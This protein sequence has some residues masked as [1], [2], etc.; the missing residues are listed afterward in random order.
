[1]FARIH[2]AFIAFGGS[3]LLLAGLIALLRWDPFAAD[4]TGGE[5]LV[6]YCA[7]A[8]R[9]PLEATARDYE[10]QFGQ[11]VYLRVGPSQ[12]ILTNLL[13]GKGGDLFLPADDSFIDL[14]RK[15]DAIAEVLPLAR[16]TAVAI[17]R[18]GYTGTIHSW[19]DFVDRGHT[20]GIAHTGSTAIGKLLRHRLTE[21]G[22]WESVEKCEPTYLTSVNEVANTVQVGGV[23][24]GVVWDAVA[25]Q[26]AK[27]K[28]RIV[29]L[30]ELDSVTA[31]VQIALTT[32]STQPDAALRFV[33]FLRSK[34]GGARYFKEQGY[35]DF[36]TEDTAQQP[37][38]VVYAGAMLR[39]AVEQ[40]LKEFATREHVKI[41]PVY[42]GC[43]IL[44]SQMRAGQKPDLYFACDTR[45]MDQVQDLF[46]PAVEV[47][48]NQLVIA[49][50]KGNP[51]GIQSLRDLGKPGLRVGVGH[52]QQCALGAI[53][54]Q[55][56]LQAG[57]Y[58]AVRKNIVVVSPTGDYLINQLRSGIGR[59]NPELDAVV[60]YK[61]NVMLFP[62]KLDGIPVTGIPCAA[63][64]QPLAVSRTTASRE[65]CEKLKTAIQSARSKE[66]FEKLGF[67]WQPTPKA[68]E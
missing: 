61:S 45:F 48:S 34:D 14:A 25:L 52:E 18:P 7:E 46:D 33:H 23:D 37:E 8:L 6:V 66:R 39:P 19:A 27:L 28:D 15:K 36:V 40:T 21:L 12:T 17:T 67:G 55:T 16:L 41:T 3:V 64:H 49:V 68:A 2:P 35:T 13:I 63:P 29:H 11:K 30:K 26:H 59:S 51:H 60:A 50:P 22:L 53:T 57:V 32:F 54:K 42:N 43:G 10:Q 5:P 44:V 20:L 62:D 56:F 47:S 31:K 1:M 58:A 24:V 65:L 4:E 38:L 9:M